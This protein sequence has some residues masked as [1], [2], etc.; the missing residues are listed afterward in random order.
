MQIGRLNFLINQLCNLGDIFF[1]F[2]QIFFTSLYGIILGFYRLI[3]SNKN[4]RSSFFNNMIF[5]ILCRI[6]QNLIYYSISSFFRQSFLE[7][8]G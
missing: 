5:I 7:Y 6:R 4:T 3:I 2:H 8:F 1:D